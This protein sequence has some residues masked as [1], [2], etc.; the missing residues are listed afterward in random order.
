MPSSQTTTAAATPVSSATVA[1]T[2]V[3]STFIPPTETCES[4]RP[5]TVTRPVSS[6]TVP[7][8][9]VCSQ[10]S[11]QRVGSLSPTYGDAGQDT[12]SSPPDSRTWIPGA[13]AIDGRCD[14]YRSVPITPTSVIPYM[15]PSGTPYRSVNARAT[16]AGTSSP[17]VVIRRSCGSGPAGRVEAS[18]PMWNGTPSTVAGVV[19]ALIAAS[20]AS[21]L[22][23]SGGTSSTPACSP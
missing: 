6:S 11:A 3:R 1:S 16:A 10:P 15:L 18:S 12:H 17:P 23:R 5:R 2:S 14:P 7:A 21:P 13:G 22:S 8:S 4:S 19:P 20:T 9:R